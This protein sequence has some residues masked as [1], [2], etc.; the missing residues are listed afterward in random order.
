MAERSEQASQSKSTC[1]RQAEYASA[2]AN[3][4]GKD[5]L[6]IGRVVVEEVYGG[7]VEGMSLGQTFCGDKT[8]HG[9]N[10]HGSMACVLQPWP[11]SHCKFIC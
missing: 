5:Q 4:H 7:G 8:M 9:H 10:I 3:M 1:L 2:W 11:W 6:H